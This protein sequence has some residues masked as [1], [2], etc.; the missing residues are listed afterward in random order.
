M[1]SVHVSFESPFP[2]VLAVDGRDRVVE[3]LNRHGGAA[4]YVEREA[5]RIPGTSGWSEVYAADGYRLRCE[6]SALG[7]EQ[8]MSFI[9][10]APEPE[11]VL[12]D[13]MD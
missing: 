12:D 11:V 5:E 3:F 7:S 10:I 13:S 4:P 9:E 2:S 1:T 8:K 6:W